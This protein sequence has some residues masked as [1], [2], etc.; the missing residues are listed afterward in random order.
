MTWSYS[1]EA[2]KKISSQFN[3]KT[4][5]MVRESYNNNNYDAE[6]D[7][8]HRQIAISNLAANPNLGRYSD[9]AVINN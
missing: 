3:G 8:M 7:R 9:N 5:S 4:T 1:Q 2:A 6:N